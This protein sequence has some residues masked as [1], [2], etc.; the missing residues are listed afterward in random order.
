MLL[1]RDS[2]TDHAATVSTELA[3]LEKQVTLY[4]AA[5]DRKELQE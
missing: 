4:K 2:A 1:V 5:L 3:R